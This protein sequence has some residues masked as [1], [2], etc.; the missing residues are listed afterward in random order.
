MRFYTGAM[1]MLVAHASY[2]A[3]M[4]LGAGSVMHGTHEETDLQ[5]MGGLIRR[6]PVTGWTFV[7]GA[8]A[9][10]GVFP[11]AGFF[12]K[13]QILEFANRT[14]RTW[15]YVLGTLGALLSALYIGRLLFLA[16][17]GRPR[18]E[19][20]EHAHESPAVMTIPLVI[21]AAGAIVAGLLL[22]TSAEGT[23]ARVLEPVVGSLPPHEGGLPTPALLV[24]ATAIALGALA[25]AW[26]VY[27]SGRV[28]WLTLRERLQPLPRAARSGWYVD[29]AYSTLFVQP[30]LAA[31]RFSA[32]VFDTKVVDGLVNGVGAGTRRFAARCP[33]H[34]DG[35]RALLRARVPPRRRRRPRLAGDAAVNKLLTLTTF[36]PL[37]GALMVLGGGRGLKDGAARWVALGVSVATFIV[38]LVVLGRFDPSSSETF[39]M[40]EIARWVPSIGLS[41]AVG[42]DG[43][44]I[45]MLL[46]TTFL[47][48][49]SILASWTITK[50]VRRY[51]AA[52]LVLETA[53]IGTFVALDL[54]LFFLFFEAL[55][56]PMYLL[57][58]GWGG[59]RRIYAAIKFFLF[60][61][62]GSAFLLVAILFL[63]VQQ[64]GP[65]LFGYGAMMDAAAGVPVTTARWLFLAFFVA[66]AVKVPL[67]PLHTWLPDAHTEAP[68]AGS[69]LLAALLLKVGTYGLIRFNLMLFPEA[70]K[71]FATFVGV[72]AVI[73][74]VY[75][76]VNALIQTDIK[77]LV[78]YSSVSH[79]GFVVLG[80]FAFTQQGV[81]GGVLQMVNHGLATGAL[82]LL[83]GMVY[84]RTHTR[85]LGSMGGLASVMPWLMG[86]FLF[87][88]FASAG[89]PGLNGFVGEFLVIVGTFAVH[90]WL[91]ALAA[92]AVVL[93][94]IYLLWSYQ[95]MAF[96]PVREEHRSLPDVSLREV[97]VLA[98]VL[99]LLLVFGVAPK[100]L[101]DRI[102][103][104]TEAVIARVAPNHQ[105][106]VGVA[107][108]AIVNP[109]L[110]EEAAP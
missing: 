72:I 20:A 57:I 99:A 85:D 80:V 40:V 58:G 2:K 100:L 37:L 90:S 93:A 74:I 13:D 107:D 92:T 103:P 43:L 89:L 97:V 88:V 28:E 33:P 98:P 36:L 91:G 64:D 73:G 82:F 38:S 30:G 79:L 109:S 46:L 53:V 5:R 59:Q 78:A 21:L 32:N 61:M 86:A 1:F 45:W 105:T 70:S 4:F 12:A 87:T 19:E 22:S 56:V 11:L 51:L 10:A 8:C 84:E 31:A 44:S 81:T 39:Q 42:I 35:V 41:Y 102:D 62:A 55:L 15:V 14:G 60:T 83:V 95:R 6:M 18:S 24:I 94:A 108:R 77:R 49:V 66:F 50:D 65:R 104:A 16:F 101:T 110:D 25:V 68:T 3:L 67:V 27:A 17:F 71:Y 76:A 106:D 23:L 75:G 48:P 26:W 34:P 52:I 63:Y 54:L 96:G 69:V 29:N 9:L 47:F 7:V